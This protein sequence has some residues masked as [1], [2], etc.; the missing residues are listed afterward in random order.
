M[1]SHILG[2]GH[3]TGPAWCAEDRT[4][5]VSEVDEAFA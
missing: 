5:T 2:S 3:L 4:Q 1:D